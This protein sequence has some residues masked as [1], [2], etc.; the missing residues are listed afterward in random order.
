MTTTAHDLSPEHFRSVLGAFPTG[1]VAVTGIGP[2]GQPAGLAIG[3]FTAV[4]LEP[5]LVA[6]LPAKSSTSWPLIAPGGVFCVNVLSADQQPECRRFSQPGA[7]KFDATPWRPAPSGSPILEA[8]LAWIDCDLE[9][10]V[11]AGDHEIVL[12]RV[13]SMAAAEHGGDPLVFFRG[14]LGRFAETPPALPGALQDAVDALAAG[15]I[16]AIVADAGPYVGV[17]ATAAATVTADDIAFMTRRA[18][19]WVCLALPS[20][21]CDALG[22]APMASTDRAP[23]DAQFTVTVE[24]RLGV[25]TGISTADQ[26][27]TMRT[28][29]HPEAGPG[30]LVVP[31]HVRPLRARAGGV[32]ERPGPTEAAI[33]LAELA[34]LP[35]AAVIGQVGNANG[36]VAATAD[37]A[38]FAAEHGLRTVSIAEL[39]A[40][41]RAAR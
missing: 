25:T 9:R 26:A 11:D 4:S 3:S 34:G 23:F 5:P 13:R 31:G 30:D 18:G 16:V 36:S 14:R 29:A 17:L 12:G 10:V 39:R 19:G 8:A 35:P 41:C 7:D 33:A 37:I 32:L 2:D 1:V 27:T 15:E 21:R 38:A 40:H 6:F 22:L 20:D 24:A 28:L